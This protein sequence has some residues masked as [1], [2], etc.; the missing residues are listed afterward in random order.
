MAPTS[1]PERHMAD[2]KHE[3][4]MLNTRLDAL[5]VKWQLASMKKALE[6]I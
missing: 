5:T 1:S 6:M 2:I 3:L 4:R